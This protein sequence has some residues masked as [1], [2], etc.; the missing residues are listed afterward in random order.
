[1]VV[2]SERTG[3]APEAVEVA[4]SNV[5]LRKNIETSQRDVGNGDDA[6]EPATA[7]VYDEVHYIDG[8]CPT[9]EQ[10]EECFGEMWDLHKDDGLVD[11]EHVGRLVSALAAALDDTNAA[12]LEIGD[13]IGGE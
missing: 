4:G 10:V 8:S 1:M 7:Y 13:M 6:N 2:K 5:W 9:K 12:L 11:V 3:D